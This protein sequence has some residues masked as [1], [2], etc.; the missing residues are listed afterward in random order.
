MFSASVIVL[1]SLP[2]LVFFKKGDYV[3]TEY[4]QQHDI[5]KLIGFINVQMGRGPASMIKVSSFLMFV[6]FSKNV[7][8]I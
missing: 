5:D 4:V 3:G 2:T 6:T 7:N 8:N 1:E